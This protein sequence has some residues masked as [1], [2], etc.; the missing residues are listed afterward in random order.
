[1]MLAGAAAAQ[2]G[3]GP[4]PAPPPPAIPAPRDVRFDGTIALEVDATD[5]RHKVFKV[6]EVI[7]VQAPGDLVLLYPE[8]DAASHAASISVSRLAGLVIHAGG[9]RI[10]WRRD[11]GRYSHAFHLAVPGEVRT[12]ELDFQ[13]LSPVSGTPR[14]R[15]TWP[16]CSGSSCCSIPLVG[17]RAI[18]RSP[19]P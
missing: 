13:Y 3:V 9:A 6:H 19:R 14:S 11:L 8:W 10:E 12:V 18:F 5:T 17:S 7:P 1:M 2:V 16:T 4:Q 15:R